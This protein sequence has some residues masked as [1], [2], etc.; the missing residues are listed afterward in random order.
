MLIQGFL[1]YI[2]ISKKL[3][4]YHHWGDS[5]SVTNLI[6][7]KNQKSSVRPETHLFTYSLMR[8]LCYE[9][10]VHSPSLNHSCLLLSLLF[11]THLVQRLNVCRVT[12]IL[13]AKPHLQFLVYSWHQEPQNSIL[14]LFIR[15][16]IRKFSTFYKNVHCDFEIYVCFLLNN[17]L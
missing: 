2:S 1:S 5:N 9:M 17:P 12:L 8:V 6:W 3:L 10:L 13:T 16:L 4:E 15:T 11:L 7:L 14:S